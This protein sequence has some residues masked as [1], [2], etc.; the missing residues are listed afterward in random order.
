MLK[1][2]LFTINDEYVFVETYSI[3]QAFGILAEEGFD[4]IAD[5]VFIRG[6]S[7]PLKT[8]ARSATI[9]I[10]ILLIVIYLL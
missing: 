5:E 2:Y 10:D 8:Q 1:D 6:M 9:L 3:D 4:L 7:T